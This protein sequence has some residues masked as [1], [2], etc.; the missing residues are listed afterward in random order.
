MQK[1]DWQ[2]D[3]KYTYIQFIVITFKNRFKKCSKKY[4][5]F[6]F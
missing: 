1:S 6:V 5:D 2:T 4:I 3:S